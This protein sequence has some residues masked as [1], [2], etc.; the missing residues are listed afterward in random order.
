MGIAEGFRAHRQRFN[1]YVL[2]GKMGHYGYGLKTSQ[3]MASDSI[4]ATEEEENCLGGSE[5]IQG[6]PHRKK[7]EKHR[8]K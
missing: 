4:K 2:L 6:V 1:F 5:G 8:Y 3:N 7:V